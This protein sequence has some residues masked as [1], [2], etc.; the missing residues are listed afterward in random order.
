[1]KVINFIHWY[2]V[3]KTEINNRKKYEFMQKEIE[4]L[5]ERISEYEQKEAKR[6]QEMLKAVENIDKINQEYTSELKKWRKEA[7]MGK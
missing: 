5:N 1:M 7:G 4:Y 2:I 6:Q 3:N